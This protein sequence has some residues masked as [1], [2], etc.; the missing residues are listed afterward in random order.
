MNEKKPVSKKNLF[1]I[2]GIIAIIVIIGFL[3]YSQYRK[4]EIPQE[5]ETEETGT[6]ELGIQTREEIDKI[7][8]EVIDTQNVSLC[9]KLKKAEDKEFCKINA[10]V[11]EATVKRDINIC[12]QI[13][14]E[15]T[16]AACR[17][18]VITGQAMDAKDP[19]ICEAITDKTRREKCE[20]I[21]TR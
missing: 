17:D 11:A 19:S 6:E 1:I 2:L 9:E 20:E 13:E 18:N 5:G 21:A 8:K 3:I 10:T 4:P 15:Y 12:N 7:I 14:N 16:K